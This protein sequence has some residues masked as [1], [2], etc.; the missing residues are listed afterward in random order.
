M[1]PRTRASGLLSCSICKHGWSWKGATRTITASTAVLVVLTG[2]ALSTPAALAQNQSPVARVPGGYR[3]PVPS[4]TNAVYH[5]SLDSFRITDTRSVHNDTDMVTFSIAVGKNKPMTFSKSMGDLNNGT[6]TVNLGADI[7]PAHNDP[8]AISYVIVNSGYNKNALEQQLK[9]WTEDNAK[10][11]AAEG[12][13]ALGSAIGGAVGGALGGAIGTK[14]GEWLVNKLGSIVFADCDGTVAAGNHVYSG[15]QLAAQTTSGRTISATDRN[16]GTD[17]PWGCGNNSMYYVSWS[18]R[19]LTPASSGPVAANPTTT[20]T[21][22]KPTRV[23]TE[24]LRM[25]K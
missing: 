4:P 11:A 20:P 24:R 18:I 23:D 10:K 15:A 25:F 2:L 6:F 19:L 21:V 8:I 5:V 9:K 13:T 1:N 14:A 3:P 22:G 12:A 16:P 7:S 17:S